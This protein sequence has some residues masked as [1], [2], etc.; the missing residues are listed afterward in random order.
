MRRNRRERLTS[1]E[2]LKICIDTKKTASAN[3]KEKTEVKETH[4]KNEASAITAKKSTFTTEIRIQVEKKIPVKQQSAISVGYKCTKVFE[5]HTDFIKAV[6]FY[7]NSKIIT[8]ATDRIVKIWDIQTGECVR[9]ISPSSQLVKVLPNGN[10]ICLDGL[11][12]K[13]IRILNVE[14][15]KVDKT[16]RGHSHAV[17]SIKHVDDERLISGGYD[18]TIIIWDY[19]QGTAAKTLHGHEDM[20]C[21]LKYLN[22]SELIIS[23]SADKTLRVWNASTGECLNKLEGHKSNVQ[24]LKL[25]DDVRIVSASFIGDIR[26]WNVNTA[27]C[28]HEFNDTYGSTLSCL[29]M[30]PTNRILVATSSRIKILDVENRKC[31]LSVRKMPKIDS[32]K[33]INNNLWCVCAGSKGITVCDLTSGGQIARFDEGESI[34]ERKICVFSNNE[35]I[36]SDDDVIKIWQ[37]DNLEKN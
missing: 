14:D 19:R 9:T 28:I 20:I 7:N 4:V 10:I 22:K 25:I 32:V 17:I 23:G 6:K 15:A 1:A 13:N 5:G 18:K 12:S 2:L 36:A 34:H 24:R 31:L 29:K 37:L 35:I 11:T 8:F 21:V 16:L 3:D 30:L 26:I 27:E 33:L